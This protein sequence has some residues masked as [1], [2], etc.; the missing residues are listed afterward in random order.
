VAAD[1]RTI[2][3]VPDRPLDEAQLRKVI[4]K[5]EKTASKLANWLKKSIPEGLTVLDFPN[6]D[7]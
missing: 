2:F 7:P 4:A 3:N 1:I 6:A 5:Y